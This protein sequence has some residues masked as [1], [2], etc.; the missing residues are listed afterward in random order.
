MLSETGVKYPIVDTGQERFFGNTT[1]IVQPSAGNPFYGQDAEYLG[2]Q[3]AFQDNGDGTVA[4]LNTGLMWQKTPDLDNQS[5]FDVALPG[6]GTLRLAGYSDWRLPTIKELYSL[7]DFKGSSFSRVPYID[8]DYFDFRFGDESAGERLIDAQYWSSTEYVGTTMNGDATVFGVNF[9]DG[10]IK[11]Y[12][13]DIGPGGL[14]ATH[15]VRYVRGNPDYGVNNFLGLGDGTITDIATGLQWQKSDDGVARNWEEALGYAESLTLGGYDD[16]RLPNAKELQSLLDYSKAPDAT[17]PARR[18]PAINTDFFQLTEPESWFWTGTTHLDAPNPNFAVY[19][20]FGQAYGYMTDPFGNTNYMNVH[21]AG[22]Q[23][24]DPKSG[25]PQ[26]WAGGH[27]PQ[28]DEVRIYNYARCVRGGEVS[29]LGLNHEDPSE[30]PSTFELGQNY[31]NPF[32]PG[33]TIPFSV[34]ESGRVTLKVFNLLAQEVATLLDEFHE[35]G[36]GSVVFNPREANVQ[37]SGLPSGV[38]FYR[39]TAGDLVETRRMVLLQ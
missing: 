26:D 23:R 27:G 9:A 35:A 5:T 6:A 16:W 1:E 4:D 21:G 7:I 30:V 19:I 39:L 14:P 17:D 37:G 34:P 24:S 3:P 31:P 2:L 25:D 36:D 28:G 33:T 32:N 10:R 29:T 12:P 22:A 15:F 13:R 38:Y 8:T 18:G 11:G 20:C